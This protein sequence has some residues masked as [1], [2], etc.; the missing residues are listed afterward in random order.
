MVKISSVEKRSHAEKQ[1]IKENDILLSVNGNNINDVLDYRFYIMDSRLELKLKRNE[2]E[3][4]AVIE[5]DENDDMIIGEDRDGN[6]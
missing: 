2:E 3:F 1:G 4:S 5:K 6:K